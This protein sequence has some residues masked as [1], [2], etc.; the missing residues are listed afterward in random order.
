[1]S[2]F[3]NVYQG[4]DGAIYLS[5]GVFST[6]LTRQQ[7]IDLHINVYD[8]PDFNK[9]RFNQ[10]YSGIAKINKQDEYKQRMK[11]LLDALGIKSRYLGPIIDG[12][13]MDLD[14]TSP[15]RNISV[16]DANI[17]ADVTTLNGKVLLTYYTKKGNVILST[18]KGMI[19]GNWPLT[20]SEIEEFK[21]LV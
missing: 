6:Q 5:L 21:K 16:T 7:I 8:L 18:S 4:E 14:T 17:R 1:M 19:G 11:S 3:H 20:P 10:N 15:Y 2:K 9:I 13:P 12:Q